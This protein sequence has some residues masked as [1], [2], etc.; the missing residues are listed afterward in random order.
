MKFLLFILNLLLI[1]VWLQS[2]SA[3]AE[4]RVALVISN[5][6]Y[7]SVPKI[8]NAANDGAAI[9]AMLRSENFDVTERNDLKNV[10]LRKEVRDFAAKT[11]D[12]DLA[13]VYFAGHGMEVGGTN[14]LI[15]TDAALR[16]DLDVEDEA[17]ALDRVL[18]V[19][20]PAKR[21]RLVI[22]DACRN[23][24]F[25]S[26]MKRT[27]ASRSVVRGLA[28]V[29]P[30][31]PNTL[32]AFAAKAGS[33]AEDGVGDHSPFTEALLKNLPEPG[34]DIRLA[35]GRV[36]DD[37]LQRTSNG[38]EPF[39]YGSLGGDV[40]TLSINVTIA[41]E[42]TDGD[43][44]RK[45]FA[46]ARTIGTLDGWKAFLARHDTGYVADM[47][48][49]ERDRLASLPN[50]SASDSNSLA[51]SPATSSLDAITKQKVFTDADRSRVATIIERDKYP[52]PEYS[53]DLIPADAAGKFGMFVGVWASDAGFN[54]GLG[55]KAMLIIDQIDNNGNFNAKF[56]IG[57]PTPQTLL[58]FPARVLNV[59]GKI[60]QNKIMFNT[61]R[62][63]AQAS[64]MMNGNFEL[65]NHDTALDRSA[66]ITLKPRWRLVD[67][68][69][70]SFVAA[71][72]CGSGNP[73]DRECSGNEAAKRDL[74]RGPMTR[75]IK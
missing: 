21:L 64:L 2:G 53:F 32:V 6:D 9:A 55:P 23:N 59:E 42:K 36:R 19:I 45:D 5:S 14:F 3:H 13:V 15:P 51:I 4:M 62:S 56:V 33:T 65:I 75:D 61:P 17:L 7:T 16:S 8:P 12:A 11:R 34:L 70:R 24:P 58:K 66:S 22:L 72:P 20:E 74:K 39:V 44:A 28:Q 68:A 67:R 52:S 73:Q 41:V 69:P 63:T 38:Q 46:I 60:N 10:E 43:D 57:P 26:N 48:R 35:L 29:E 30:S 37:V 50:P 18:Q 40:V 47:A 49:R 31:R 1:F 71:T 27:M 25:I 54:G